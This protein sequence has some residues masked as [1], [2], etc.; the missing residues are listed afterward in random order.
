MVLIA[1]LG[2]KSEENNNTSGINKVFTDAK[3]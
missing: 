3:K 2:R 1:K